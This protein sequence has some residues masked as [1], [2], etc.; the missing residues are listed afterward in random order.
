MK[1]NGSERP[2]T[3]A[4][5]AGRIISG[6]VI[7]F[8]VLDGAMKVAQVPM[9]L[10]ASA[11]LGFSAAAVFSIGLILLICTLLYAIPR[12]AILGAVLL[13]GYLGGAAATNLR[14]GTPLFTNVLFP[15]YMGVLAWWG[16]YL[17]DRRLRGLI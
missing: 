6:L 8:S 11:E 4:V 5:W 15:V 10:K 17:R 12:T 1:S 9:V 7:A 3:T 13:T 2:S 14:A 16:L